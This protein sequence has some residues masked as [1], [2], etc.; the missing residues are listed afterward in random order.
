MVSVTQ[1]TLASHTAVL[2]PEPPNIA[3]TFHVNQPIVP[4]HP[5]KHEFT[6]SPPCG[7]FDL[8]CA[9]PELHILFVS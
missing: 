7:L 2:D 6:D 8:L 4:H 9:A 5:P 3:P 1:R